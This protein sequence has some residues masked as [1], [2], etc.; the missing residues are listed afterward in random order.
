LPAKLLIET[1]KHDQLMAD[2]YQ[3]IEDALGERIA[4]LM[5]EFDLDYGRAM[6]AAEN[7]IYRS[8]CGLFR[9][10]EFN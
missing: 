8:S 5:Y 4:V 10:I 6:E 1:V 3:A 7:D 9:Q 2:G